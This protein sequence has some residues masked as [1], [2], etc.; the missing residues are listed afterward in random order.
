MVFFGYDRQISPRGIL[1]GAQMFVSGNFS[2]VFKYSIVLTYEC[3][4]HG[5]K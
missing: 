4:T 1:A 3:K 5:N 2:A